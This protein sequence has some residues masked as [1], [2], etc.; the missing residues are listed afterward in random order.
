MIVS[1]FHRRSSLSPSPSPRFL[2]QQ[3]GVALFMV[4]MVT[5]V[6][7]ALSVSLAVGVFGGQKSA[8]SIA[9]HAIARQAAEAALRDA[10]L[11]L[12]CQQWNSATQSFAFNNSAA[13]G[14]TNPRSFCDKV[15]DRCNQIGSTGRTP[16][17]VN[18]LVNAPLSTNGN[19][20]APTESNP[21]ATGSNCSVAYGS[22]TLQPKFELSGLSQQTQPAPPR[23]SIEQFTYNPSGE[24]GKD[25]PAYRITARGYGRGNAATTTVDLE[26]IYRPCDK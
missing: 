1:P 4:L 16:T 7:V 22:I 10:E 6:I 9:D 18:G 26:S 12:M 8:R 5:L 23:Y 3:R 20:P 21:F 19:V 17:C 15:I 11:D 13:V 14:S 2:A 24:V 25:L